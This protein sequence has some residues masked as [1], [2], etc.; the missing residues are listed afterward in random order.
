MLRHQ[1][2][3]FIKDPP[4]LSIS[5]SHDPLAMQYHKSLIANSEMD[6]VN[7]EML[8]MQQFGFDRMSAK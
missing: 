2:N 7:F 6:N 5:I 3:I 1:L 8:S 4:Q